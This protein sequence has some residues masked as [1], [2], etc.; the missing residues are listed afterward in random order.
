MRRA[1]NGSA[2]RRRRRRRSGKG[3]ETKVAEGFNFNNAIEKS[4][5]DSLLIFSINFNRIFDQVFSKIIRTS[6]PFEISIISWILPRETFSEHL[7]TYHLR[8]G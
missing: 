8:Y 2:N 1:R 3:G 7:E 5:N 4:S 6:L